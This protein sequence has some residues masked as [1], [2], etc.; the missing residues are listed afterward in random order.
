MSERAPALVRPAEPD[1]AAEIAHVSRR[2][3]TAA[4]PWLPDL[5]SP[6]DDL[7]FFRATVDRE[8]TWV[9][10]VGHEVVG[11]VC[12]DGEQVDHLYV[13]PDHQGRGVG[14]ELL[15]VAKGLGTQRLRLWAFQRN[16]PARAFYAH[17]GF[18][19]VELTD[20]AGNEEHEPDVCLEWTRD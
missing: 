16:E 15:S 1:D 13:A 17:H 11:F 20:G 10:L 3:R 4:M 19:E 14:A 18:G 2:A 6:D 7:R 5:H 8:S 9:A 12:V